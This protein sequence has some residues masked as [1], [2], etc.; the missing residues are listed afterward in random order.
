MTFGAPV[1]RVL[2]RVATLLRLTESFV[3]IARVYRARGRGA[4]LHRSSSWARLACARNDSNDWSMKNLM[5]SALSRRRFLAVV[6][7]T[8]AAIGCSS[9]GAASEATGT[10]A[11]GNVSATAVGQIAF[12]PGSPLILG[13][14]AG[15]L[16]AMTSV[17]THQRCDMSVDGS[18]RASGVNCS[19]HG[20]AFTATGAVASGPARAPLQHFQVQVGAGGA[21]SINADVAVDSATRTAVS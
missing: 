2:R 8:A 16:Y 7:G 12:V 19:C 3:G 17:C 20:S 10:I 18:I 9:S 5:E 15:G 11:A 21:I 14:D 13:R 1:A 4:P 6:G